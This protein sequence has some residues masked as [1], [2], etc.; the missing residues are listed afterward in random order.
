MESLATRW[1]QPLPPLVLDGIADVMPFADRFPAAPMS[2]S[3]PALR[4]VDGGGERTVSRDALVAAAPGMT[5]ERK[6]AGK[7]ERQ[8]PYSLLNP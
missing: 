1:P 6:Q 5:P 3:E 8:K 4:I 2:G 7:R